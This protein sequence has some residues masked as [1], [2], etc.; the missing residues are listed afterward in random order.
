ME[1]AKIAI[2]GRTLKFN[3]ILGTGALQ[4]SEIDGDEFAESDYGLIVDNGN[5]VQE[6]NSKMDML[7]QAAL[8]NQALSF[9]T[10][11]KLYSSCSIAEKQRM[12]ESNEKRMQEQ[13]EQQQQQQMQLAQETL[14]QKTQMEQAKMEQEYRMNVENNDT[15]VLIAQI[16]S[17]AEADRLSLMNHDYEEDVYTEKD[18]ADLAERIREFDAK[19]KLDNERLAFEKSKAKK[20]QEL[21]ARQ[22]SKQSKN[23]TKK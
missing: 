8:Q 17:Q 1:T 5:A 6:L 23:N 7:A 4:V 19:L 18:K 12:V 16:N 21:K 15:K 22:I 2:K 20:D 10:I 13:Q 3:Y 14:Q 11:M 9:S